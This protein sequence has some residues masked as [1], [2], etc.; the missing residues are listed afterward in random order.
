MANEDPSTAPPLAKAADRLRETSKWLITVFAGVGGALIAGSQLSNIG[1]LAP[2]NVVRFLLAAAGV[3][4]ALVGVA[5]AIGAAVK[6][7]TAGSVD[8]RGLANLLP[9]DSVRARLE[10]DDVLMSRYGSLTQLADAYA[11]A[12]AERQTAYE[13]YNDDR[14][15]TTKA[16]DP[17]KL[18]ALK[19][20]Q[21]QAA[22]VS[23]T[24]QDV[25][26]VG[27]FERIAD[28][29]RR[30]RPHLFGGA[31]AAAIGIVAFAAA[32]NPADKDT[33]FSTPSITASV[34]DGG[35][36]L[37]ASFAADSLATD[38]ELRIWITGR[39]RGGT[40]YAGSFGPDSSGAVTRTVRIPL[41]ATPAVRQ[42][43]LR[44]WKGNGGP[45]KC[46]IRDRT[47]SPGKTAC[48]VLQLR[49]PGVRPRLT[50]TWEGN[51]LV[52]T[53]GSSTVPATRAL[54]VRVVAVS[55]KRRRRLYG[56]NLGSA[57]GMIDETIKLHVPA[58]SE[59]VC[60]EAAIVPSRDTLFARALAT[61]KRS[62]VCPQ[63][64]G[65]KR[66]WVRLL[67]PN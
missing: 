54:A 41:R 36:S 52:V 8:L 21:G 16:N 28:T 48:L 40:L 31:A 5:W 38:D 18:V 26:E 49:G 64:R 9:T 3:I 27:S 37:D 23:Q 6:V 19:A 47:Q 2:N 67:V 14:K 46:N 58:G 7:Q 30:A 61:R 34:S 44:A 62:T 60:A 11:E 53:V 33:R 51:D 57:N 45:A 56:A 22:F 29:F 43:L 15:D 17:A 63:R 59:A 55:A 1:H 24:V 65:A 10:R 25:L 12:V 4:L 20:A 42:V 39:P 50:A 13:A 66:A 32:A 35:T